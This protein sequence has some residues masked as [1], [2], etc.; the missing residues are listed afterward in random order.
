MTVKATVRRV[1]GVLAL[2]ALLAAVATAPASAADPAEVSVDVAGCGE[3][4]VS[5]SLPEGHSI[6]NMY[7]VVDVDGVAQSVNIPTDG[8]N[9]SLTAGPFHGSSVE[10][11]TVSWRVFGG[12]ER[13]LDNP[14]W[15]GHGEPGFGADIGAYA[16]EV[17][18][19]SWVI[20]GTD[21][22]NP[23]TTWNEVDVQTCAITKQMCKKGGFADFGFR[24]QGQCIRFVNTG[25]DSR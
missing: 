24:N 8:S 5:A 14:L 25:R 17:G 9:V 2:A 12:G 1:S 16:T 7:L 3:T 11:E 18:S 20:A 6:D 10:A 15:N 21:D 23:F 4:T 22:P 19:F 13:D